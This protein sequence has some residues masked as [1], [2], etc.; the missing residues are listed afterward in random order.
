MD[1]VASAVESLDLTSDLGFHKPSFLVAAKGL[2]LLQAVHQTLENTVVIRPVDMRTVGG[3]RLSD[4]RICIDLFGGHGQ[5]NISAEQASISFTNLRSR[6]DLE[7]CAQ[8]IEKSRAAIESILSDVVISADNIWLNIRFSLATS[9][10]EYGA[11]IQ[12]I[13]SHCLPDSLSKFPHASHSPRVHLDIE[14]NG[15]DWTSSFTLG[16]GNPASNEIFILGH[17]TYQDLKPMQMTNDRIGHSFSLVQAFAE[18]CYLA[19]TDPPWEG[20]S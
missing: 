5:V 4:V 3:S 20:V 16:L 10:H 18:S 11:T 15:R 6:S 14:D 2:Q 1:S 9:W 17:L 19:V 13:S 12:Q 8:C 7:L